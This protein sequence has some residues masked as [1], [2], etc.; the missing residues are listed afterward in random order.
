MTAP[1]AQRQG[2]APP[3]DAPDTM[4]VLVPGVDEQH[5]QV[6]AVEA[7]RLA[8]LDLPRV[9]GR[10]ARGL[11]PFFGAGF[12]GV[13]WIHPYLWWQESGTRPFTMTKLA[14]KVIP[15]WVDDADGSARRADPKAKTRITEDGRR[16]VLIFRRAARLGQRKTVMRRLAGRDVPTSVPASYPGA[17]GRIAARE[18]GRISSGN[19]G[20]RWRHPGLRPRG[21]IETAVLK[22]AAAAGLGQP[23]VHTTRRVQ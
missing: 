10:S 16:Q 8:R 13:S 4:Y 17:P 3:S 22:V 14:G 12:F 15:M 18:G 1:A 23:Q 21:S 20:V 11:M 9:T 5:A 6:L 19:V 7:V 2:S